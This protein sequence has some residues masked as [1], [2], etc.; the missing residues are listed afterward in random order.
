MDGWQGA[1]SSR[2]DVNTFASAAADELWGQHKWPSDF[3]D[4]KSG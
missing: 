2:G 4:G 3:A 1:P